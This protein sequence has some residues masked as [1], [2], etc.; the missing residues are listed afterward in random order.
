MKR[1]IVSAII[2]LFLFVGFFAEVFAAPIKMKAVVF[3]PINNAMAAMAV[4][5]VERMNSELGDQINVSLGGPEVLPGMQQPDA[6]KAG[7]VDIAFTV[8]AYFSS[9]FPEGWSFFCSKFTPM[10]ERAPGGFYD[11]MVG[12]FKKINMMYLGRWLS[13]ADFYLWTS[14]PVS[15]LEDLKGLKMRTAAHFDRFMKEMGIVPVTVS[16]PDT[17]TALERGVVEGVGWPLLGT[18]ELGWTGKCKYIIDHPFHGTQNAVLVMNLDKWKKLPKK[19][20][21]K[22][23]SLTAKYEADVVEHFKKEYEKEWELIKKEGVKRVKFAQADKYLDI[24]NSVDW[25]IMNEKTPKLV[26]DLKRVTGH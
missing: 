24:I 21:S 14:K 11:Y 15:K 3:L 2:T 5:W 7:V 1:L 9:M 13:A 19:L 25:E 26:K 4:E 10:E 8:T 17:Y 18:R 23:V 6:V 22:L 20:Q 12:R 16:V